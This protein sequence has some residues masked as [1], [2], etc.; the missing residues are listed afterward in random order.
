MGLPVVV[1]LT[2]LRCF[3]LGT[4]WRVILEGLPFVVA[5]VKAGQGLRDG[6]DVDGGGMD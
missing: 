5:Q 1:Q 4:S 2:D 3:A 6:V